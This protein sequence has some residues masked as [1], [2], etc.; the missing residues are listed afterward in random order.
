MRPCQSFVPEWFTILCID[1]IKD[2][3]AGDGVEVGANQE[4]RGH[5]WNTLFLF[6]GDVSVRYVS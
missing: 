5:R 3:V 1:A 4:R 6:P 2:V